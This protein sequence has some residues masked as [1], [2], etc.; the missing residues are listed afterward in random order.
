MLTGEPPYQGSTAQAIVA[1]VITE[2]PRPI[3]LQRRTVPPHVADAVHKALNKLPAD[4][5]SSAASLAEALVTP[6]YVTP[7]HTRAGTAA[8][9]APKRRDWQKWGLAAALVVMTSLAAWA[10]LWPG[11]PA[12]IAR[13]DLSL[14]AIAEPG[15]S[16]D[17]VVSPDGSMLAVASTSGAESGIYVRR[18]GEA[19]FRRLPGTENARSP[20]FSPDGRWLVYRNNAENTLVKVAVSGGSLL[21][22]LESDSIRPF[23]PDWGEQGTIVFRSPLGVHAISAGGGTARLLAHADLAPGP[24][25]LLPDG[26]GILGANS[27]GGIALYDMQGDSTFELFADGDNPLYI[28]S[29]PILYVPR[30]GGLFAVPFDLHSRRVTGPAVRV[31]DRVASGF[32]RRGFSVS[33]E[34]TLVYLEG[35]ATNAGGA[36]RP[37]RFLLLDASGRADTLRLPP[38]RYLYPH[39]APDGRMIAYERMNLDRDNE[40]DIYTF[41][42]VTGTTTQITFDGDNDAP[43]WS[44]DGMRLLYDV[45]DSGSD[46]TVGEDLFIKPA[47]NSSAQTRIL[48]HPGDQRPLAWLADDRLVFVSRDQGSRNADLMVMPLADSSAVQPYLQAPWNEDEF[49]LSPDGR[50]AAFVSNETET[51]EVWLRDF[52]TPEGK[53]RVSFG[54]GGEPRWSPDGSTLYFWRFAPGADTLKAVRVTRT[55]RVSVGSAEVVLVRDV[56]AGWD[57]HPDGRRFLVV[58]NEAAANP[59]QAAAGQ[60]SDRYLVVLNWYEELKQRMAAK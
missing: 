59:A 46:S 44:P 42:L 15:T 47:D 36:G 13:L 57:L 49:A 23:W 21:T 14:G 34:G 1:R 60:S 45:E 12:T 3:T 53:W 6:G 51:R 33:R 58:E 5:F 26:S 19:D 37:T 18:I 7:S 24:I 4:R 20:A 35:Q 2:E 25:Q 8:A 38:G 10:W 30:T 48:S 17:V 32:S 40:T 52:P 55:P 16:S 22:L 28:A 41:D 50:L 27:N 43:L 54:G 29:G 39:F 56:L 9:T 31:L 11:P